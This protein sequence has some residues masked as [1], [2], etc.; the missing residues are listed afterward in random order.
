MRSSR[1]RSTRKLPAALTSGRLGSLSRSAGP[2]V[3]LTTRHFSCSSPTTSHEVR[4][5]RLR[6]AL[7][8]PPSAQLGQGP[9]AGGRLPELSSRT[10]RS[11]YLLRR[12]RKR[13]HEGRAAEAH[14]SQ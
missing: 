12:G 2:T 6:R 5:R 4:P 7:L 3:S 10:D 13:A 9:A 1:L 11:V 14:P 8:G